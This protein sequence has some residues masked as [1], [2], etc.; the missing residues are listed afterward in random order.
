MTFNFHGDQHAAIINNVA[1][2]Q[3]NL[4][5]QH[6]NGGGD[7]RAVVA[8][9]RRQLEATAM[10]GGVGAAALADVANIEA[11][12]RGR[13]PDRRGI[14]ERLTRLTQLLHTAGTLGTAGA[15]L[16]APLGAL[17][18]WLGALGAPILGMLAG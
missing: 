1:G 11:E 6:A 15:A 8:E 16:R 5:G 14:A 18:N 10:P 17:A 7:V 12:V 4:G 9:L 13:N 3:T 2:D